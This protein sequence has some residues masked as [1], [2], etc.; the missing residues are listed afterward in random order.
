MEQQ[1]L[2]RELWADLICGCQP[3]NATHGIQA[4][5]EIVRLKAEGYGHAEIARSL[6]RRGISTPTG[7]GRWWPD[8][9][10]RHVDPLARA[11][12]AAS[13]RRYRAN[14]VG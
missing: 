2:P 11:R 3:V 8:T 6:N 12:W 7:R 5:A 4:R 9:V 1:Q 13:M 10:R 14:R